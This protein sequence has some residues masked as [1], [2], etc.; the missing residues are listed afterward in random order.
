M[1]VNPLTNSDGT[2][3]SDLLRPVE[4]GRRQARLFSP[5]PKN[6]SEKDVG[7]FDAGALY[8]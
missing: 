5:N 1:E 6:L 2:S 3:K 8:R 7:S 4:G